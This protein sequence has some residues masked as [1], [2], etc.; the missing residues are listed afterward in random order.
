MNKNNHI[1]K[2]NATKVSIISNFCLIILKL[3]AG[4]ISGSISIIS[5][6]IHSS[7][8]LLASFIAYFAVT[9]PSV[10]PADVS[11]NS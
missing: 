9:A 11:Y 1:L 6:A 7:T 2:R 8:D 5:E 10:R 4:I 3:F